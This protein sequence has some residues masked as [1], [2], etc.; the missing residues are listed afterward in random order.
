MSAAVVGYRGETVR[1]LY[2]K[3]NSYRLTLVSA[4]QKLLRVTAMTQ[5]LLATV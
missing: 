1:P 2:G 4:Q 3:N 5:S